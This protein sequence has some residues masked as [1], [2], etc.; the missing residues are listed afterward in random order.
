MQRWTHDF[1]PTLTELLQLEGKV[2]AAHV[3]LGRVL[4]NEAQHR[5]NSL[6]A[7]TFKCD[8]RRH[9]VHLAHRPT[10]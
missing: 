7:H 1:A 9:S 3:V 8:S 2:R 10:A 4:E 5:S 6:K